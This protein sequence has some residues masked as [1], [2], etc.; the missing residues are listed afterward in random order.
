[1]SNRTRRR[2]AVGAVLAALAVPGAAIAACKQVSG[3]FTSVLVPPPTCTSGTGLC[4]L[5]AL[6][7]DLRASYF[8][9]INTLA[10]SGNPNNPA[11]LAY[12]GTSVI[13]I[14]H[15]GAQL[16]SNDTGVMDASNPFAV[17]FVTTVNIYGGT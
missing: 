16:F 6:T 5:G 12:T 10:P 3:P 7:G 8:F 2:L 9:S 1:M 11:E 17:P 13:T 15:G 4:T 14:T